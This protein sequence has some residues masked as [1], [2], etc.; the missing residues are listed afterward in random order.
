MSEP[1]LCVTFATLPET[2]GLAMVKDCNT[3]VFVMT[4]L[5]DESCELVLHYAMHV[6]DNI[7]RH[8]TNRDVHEKGT[9]GLKLL[10]HVMDYFGANPVLDQKKSEL[11]DTIVK[12]EKQ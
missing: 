4:G 9:D 1:N 5:E 3:F 8:A 7:V 12:L 6:A 2:E 11:R 10:L